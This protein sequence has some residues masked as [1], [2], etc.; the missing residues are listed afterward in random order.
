MYVNDYKS[1]APFGVG[2][3]KRTKGTRLGG[4]KR[5][6]EA[7]QDSTG[8]LLGVTLGPGGSPASGEGQLCVSGSIER[9]AYSD[10]ASQGLPNCASLP[11]TQLT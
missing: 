8:L 10:N 6:W 2:K 5:T 4:E 9:S 7:C 11:D 3:G 1:G